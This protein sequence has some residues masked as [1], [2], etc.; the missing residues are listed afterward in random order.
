MYGRGNY[1]GLIC[2]SAGIFKRLS[3][4]HSLS[5]RPDSFRPLCHVSFVPA[6]L[7]RR[8]F[9]P[10]GTIGPHIL[11]NTSWSYE[12]A[13]GYD[14]GAS[15][16]KT[17]GST[18]FFNLIHVQPSFY[19]TEAAKRIRYHHIQTHCFAIAAPSSLLV[20]PFC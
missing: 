13:T 4:A 14:Q 17:Q 20:N 15:G 10:Q 11:K 6:K 3:P 1:S 8:P 5:R 19:I 7:R 12:R 18:S 16:P 2:A 9:Y